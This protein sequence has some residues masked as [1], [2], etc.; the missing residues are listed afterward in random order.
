MYIIGMR[1][2]ARVRLFLPVEQRWRK[3][4]LEYVE[5][6]CQRHVE[7]LLLAIPFVSLATDDPWYAYRDLFFGYL[8]QPRYV[9][10]VFGVNPIAR[11]HF[12]TGLKKMQA[13]TDTKRGLEGGEELEEPGPVPELVRL[14]T[15]GV[16]NIA[17]IAT[18]PR[19]LVPAEIEALKG[20]EYIVAPSMDEAT[21]LNRNYG[22]RMIPAPPDVFALEIEEMLKSETLR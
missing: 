4:A 3:L 20:Y 11:I 21:A 6:L 15:S 9:N 5:A 16:P 13:K 10:V 1:R 7:I 19:D 22:F 14:H 12:L 18:W 8:T 17:V 2:R